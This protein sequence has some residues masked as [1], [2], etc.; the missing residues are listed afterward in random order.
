MTT[1]TGYIL[2]A[3]EN[4]TGLDTSRFVKTLNMLGSSTN[5]TDG[6]LNL[7]VSGF[8]LSYVVDATIFQWTYSWKGI[9]FAGLSIEFEKGS[10][11]RLRND[12]DHTLGDTTVNITRNQAIDIASNYLASYIFT[13]AST[14]RTVTFSGN[15][16]L[17][18]AHLDYAVLNNNTFIPCWLVLYNLGTTLSDGYVTVAVLAGSGQISDV[19]ANGSSL[20]VIASNPAKTETEPSNQSAQAQSTALQPLDTPSTATNQP[21]NEPTEMLMAIAVVTVAALLVSASLWLYR[22]HLAGKRDYSRHSNAQSIMI[23]C[24]K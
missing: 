16:T 4:Y 17:Q 24:G 7:S 6:N 23:L 9:P 14:N 15:Q 13:Q 19:Q 18:D 12:L 5:V 8:K 3:L 22:I 1:A 21:S 20:H 11:Y 2:C 10:F